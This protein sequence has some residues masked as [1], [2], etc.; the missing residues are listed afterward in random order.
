MF[1]YGLHNFCKVAFFCVCVCLC[2]DRVS[3]LVDGTPSPVEQILVDENKLGNFFK[4]KLKFVW[5]ALQPIKQ[6][7]GL[8]ILRSLILNKLYYH[9]STVKINAC[10]I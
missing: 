9:I 5:I 3:N 10:T 8:F 2:V 4:D 1:K 7:L 6:S